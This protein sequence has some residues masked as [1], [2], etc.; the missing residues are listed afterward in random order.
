LDDGF[1]KNETTVDLIEDYI[2][3][4]KLVF[5]DRDGV[6][7]IM[8]SKCGVFDKGTNTWYSNNSYNHKK[9][10]FSSVKMPAKKPEV[11]K[12]ETVTI[13]YKGKT[14]TVP[15]TELSMPTA[16]ELGLLFKKAEEKKKAEEAKKN[17]SSIKV[18]DKYLDSMGATYIV[19]S[20]DFDPYFKM[21]LDKHPITINVHRNNLT[22]QYT[23][24]EEPK[25]YD[26]VHPTDTVSVT[27]GTVTTFYTVISK[28]TGT[29]GKRTVKVR[30]T[31]N[32]RN[33]IEYQEESFNKMFKLEKVVV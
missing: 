32:S 28:T 24:I 18:G 31:V 25:L 33:A 23:R 4:D 12:G 21:R 1:E 19:D 3:S 20:V 30:S 6:V 14:I 8:N 9:F 13:S 15:V 22:T 29:D 17:L 10:S 27:Y 2:G 11:K 16:S 5:L 7:T 26:E